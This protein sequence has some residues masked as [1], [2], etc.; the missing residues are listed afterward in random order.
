MEAVVLA[1]GLG[2]RLQSVVSAAPKPM[3]P[4]AGRPFLEILLESL[5]S[6]GVRRVVLS[7]GH[8]GH[9]ISDHFGDRFAGLELDY[10]VEPS[11]LGTGGGLRRA[12]SRVQA[13]WAIVANGD[14]W[15]EMDLRDLW[16][17]H[18][19][20]LEADP[21][22]RMSMTLHPVDD[23]RRYGRVAVEDG[24]VVRFEAAGAAGPGWINAG[25]YLVAS[26]LLAD[27]ALPDRFSFEAG[28]LEPRLPALRPL[29]YRVRGRFIDIGVPED[30]ARAQ[31]LLADRGSPDGSARP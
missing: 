12:L 20:A 8:L 6:G 30:Y 14:T 31:E 16:R 29:A 28:F 3:A 25:T 19:L 22:L 15:V 7:V 17:R 24:R 1:G 13:A 18:H 26:D 23:A 10:A 27:P 21:G 11:P 2:T 9:V 4:V 5:A